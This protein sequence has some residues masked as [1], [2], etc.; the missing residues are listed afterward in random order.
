[1][2]RIQPFRRFN[3]STDIN[4][5]RG[6]EAL[7]MTSILVVSPVARKIHLLGGRV[8]QRESTTVTS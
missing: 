1:M 7:A 3:I 8:A 2:S 4:F 6:P 5:N